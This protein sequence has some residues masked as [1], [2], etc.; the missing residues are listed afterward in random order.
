MKKHDV[1]AAIDQDRLFLLLQPIVSTQTHRPVFYE[2]LLRLR[3]DEGVVKAGDFIETAEQQQYVHTVDRRAL[4]LAIQLM[5]RHSGFDLA[6]NISSLTTSDFAWVRSLDE[7][8]SDRRGLASRLI[9]EITETAAIQDIGRT[10]FFI[11][12]LKDLGCRIA[13]DDY[14]AGHTNFTTLK[15]FAPHLV[16]ID[17]SYAGTATKPASQ[18][19]VAAVVDLSQR[20]GFE[21][22]AEGVEDEDCARA[23]TDLGTTYLQGFLFGG[24]QEPV[25]ALSLTAP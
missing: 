2:A 7:L 8:T 11:D 13:I 1:L 16:K 21:T 19:F 3:T 25:T 20:L 17:R 10:Q 6:M 22:V 15:A 14:G 5:E 9:V 12:S 23:L 24:P 4:E 18:A